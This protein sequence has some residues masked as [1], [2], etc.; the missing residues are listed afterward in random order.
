M[1]FICTNI[2]VSGCEVFVVETPNGFEARTAVALLGDF[3]MSKEEL[4][5]IKYNPFHTDFNDN[6]ASGIGATRE[7]AIDALSADMQQM[8]RDL[9]L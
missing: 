5:A 2:G 4:E 6:Y 9:W 7:D 3:Q 1:P 8:S